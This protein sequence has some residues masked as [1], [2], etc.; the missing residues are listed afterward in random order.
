MKWVVHYN[1]NTIVTEGSYVLLNDYFE[2]DNIKVYH[3][4]NVGKKW[5]TIDTKI[6]WKSCPLNLD[7]LIFHHFS[8]CIILKCEEEGQ[9]YIAYYYK[10][11]HSMLMQMWRISKV[12]MPEYFRSELSQFMP[13]MRSNIEKYIQ[14]W[15]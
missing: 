11:M 7:K 6:W 1:L 13:V 5:L 3:S 2:L 15:W 10:N 14:K 8:N 4:K 9:R 12:F